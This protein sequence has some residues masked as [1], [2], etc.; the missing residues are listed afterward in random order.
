[1][2]QNGS[3]QNNGFNSDFNP[4]NPKIPIPNNPLKEKNPKNDPKTNQM[5]NKFRQAFEKME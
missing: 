3:E 4:K 5:E 1:M 2:G